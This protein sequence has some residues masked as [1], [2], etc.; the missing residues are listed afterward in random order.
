MYS[1]EEFKNI[2][3]LK[4]SKKRFTHSVNVADEARKLALHYSY[5]DPDKAY[6]AGLLHDVC[7]EIPHDAQ[8]E[9]VLESERDVSEAEKQSPPLFHGIAGAYYAETVFG[10]TDEDFLSSIRYH[11]VG[12]AKMSRL[13]EIV[14]LADLISAERD[15]KD[16]D[17]MRKYCYQSLE[18]AMLEALIFS[19]GSVIKKGGLIPVPTTEAYNYYRNILKDKQ[20]N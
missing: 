14:Y 5:P 13:E 12:R 17:K 6:L 15:Y 1:V 8:L 18:K 11:T 4:L 20:K 19:I 16:V 10:F 2:L 9:M 7:K 3:E